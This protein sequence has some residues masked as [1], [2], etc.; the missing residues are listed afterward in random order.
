MNCTVQSINVTL[1]RARS[2]L[3]DCVLRKMAEIPH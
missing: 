3:R 2:F 1:S